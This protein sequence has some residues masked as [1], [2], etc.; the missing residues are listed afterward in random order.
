[1]EKSLGMFLMQRC[2]SEFDHFESL[3]SPTLCGT[4]TT[5]AHPKTD[6]CFLDEILKLAHCFVNVVGRIR[7]IKTSLWNIKFLL[8]IKVL[9]TYVKFS[10]QAI[11]LFAWN[12]HKMSLKI[13]QT[14][15]VWHGKV[16][17]AYR[18]PP[19]F[20]KCDPPLHS[21]FSTFGP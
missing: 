4:F 9:R 3:F 20:R 8:V 7:G 1:M 2:E 12:T 10:C 19:L 6:V 14:V 16:A 13:F 11:L 15:D 5:Q 17:M 18:H 21:E